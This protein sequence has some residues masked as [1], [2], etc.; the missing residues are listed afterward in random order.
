VLPIIEEMIAEGLVTLENV[1]I[2][3]YRA[4]R[5]RAEGDG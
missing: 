5:D 2:L 1:E 4:N 3:A